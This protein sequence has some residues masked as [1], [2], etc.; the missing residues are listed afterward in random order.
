MSASA[1]S[2]MVPEDSVMMAGALGGF[3]E[4]REAAGVLKGFSDERGEDGRDTPGLGVM[5]SSSIPS[6]VVWRT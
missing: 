6:S 1:G 2:Y 5:S 4:V 3:S